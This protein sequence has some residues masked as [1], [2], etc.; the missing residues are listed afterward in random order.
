[1]FLVYENEVGFGGLPETPPMSPTSPGFNGGRY[2]AAAVKH[3]RNLP[4]IPGNNSTTRT[5][6][7]TMSPNFLAKKLPLSPKASYPPTFAPQPPQQQ[8]HQQKQ[9]QQQQQ[10]LI[11]PLQYTDIDVSVYD[12][13]VVNVVGE[14][15]YLTPMFLSSPQHGNGSNGAT[16]KANRAV[17]ES[18]ATEYLYLNIHENSAGT[19]QPTLA[20]NRD[21]HREQQQQPPPAFNDARKPSSPPLPPKVKPRSAFM[22]QEVN[23][24]GVNSRQR[25][26]K[27]LPVVAS[28]RKYRSSTAT[29]GG[30]QGVPRPSDMVKGNSSSAQPAFLS[31]RV[32][33]QQKEATQRPPSPAEVTR[34]PVK[35][36][37]V[38]QFATNGGS[39]ARK[40]F[41]I[42]KSH[43]AEDSKPAFAKSPAAISPRNQ[44]KTAAAAGKVPPGNSG[45]RPVN[46]GAKKSHS[47]ENK[48]YTSAAKSSSPAAA[49]MK[50]QRDLKKTNAAVAIT[51]AVNRQP[52]NNCVPKKSNL[53]ANRM[54]MFESSNSSGEQQQQHPQGGV[55]SHVLRPVIAKKPTAA[56]NARPNHRLGSSPP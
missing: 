15:S 7:A 6:A 54:K 18:T 14:D 56:A 2:T 10:Q 30:F 46:F 36:H 21:L 23:S 44:F 53:I 3:R 9:Q 19:T 29:A 40:A 16:A 24:G 1:M 39:P 45:N 51:D 11:E 4:E 25:F 22:P 50:T 17:S 49:A 26:D 42:K 33:S 5:K 47:V 52:P 20:P 8:Q 32:T 43:S 31:S 41:G 37:H 34:A 35:H 27:P 48:S 38:N 55:L 13:N 12:D 28:P